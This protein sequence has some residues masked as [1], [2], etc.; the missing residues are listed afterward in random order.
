[1]DLT[2]KIGLTFSISVLTAIGLF[3]CYMFVE[4]TDVKSGKVKFLTTAIPYLLLGLQGIYLSLDLFEGITE[5]DLLGVIGAAF[6]LGLGLF[7]IMVSFANK[8]QDG[9][10]NY[11]EL[12]EGIFYMVMG[13]SILIVRL[14]NREKARKEAIKLEAEAAELETLK[15]EAVKW[16]EAIK[17]N[18]T[19]IVKDKSTL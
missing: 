14:S 4:Q 7:V 15:A 16:K 3:I 17:D 1:M 6:M 10:V 19:K 2:A 11:F 12:F 18:S 9:H 5:N 13:I 8:H